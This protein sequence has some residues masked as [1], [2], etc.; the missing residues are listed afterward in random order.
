ML[1]VAINSGHT[2]SSIPNVF[3]RNISY[4]W[5]STLITETA[6]LPRGLNR[7]IIAARLELSRF[8]RIG[9]YKQLTW[10]EY[11]LRIKDLFDLSLK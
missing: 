2:A 10:I 8:M 5:G 9:A 7:K 4:W 11:V 6:K 1:S 3:I